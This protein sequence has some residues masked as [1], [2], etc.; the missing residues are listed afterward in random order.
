VYET[1]PGRS[2]VAAMAPMAA[3]GIVGDNKELESVAKEADARL[4][5]ALTSLEVGIRS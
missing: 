3:L 4:R 2:V 5:H 1:S